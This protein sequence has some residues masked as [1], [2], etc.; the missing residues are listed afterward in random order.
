MKIDLVWFK[1]TDSQMSA[2]FI[3]GK[4][5]AYRNDIDN[6]LIDFVNM[7]TS[8]CEVCGIELNIKEVPW[9]YLKNSKPS[10]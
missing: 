9:E 7:L 1:A 10:P 5:I 8:T 2:I 4:E 6:K 3:N